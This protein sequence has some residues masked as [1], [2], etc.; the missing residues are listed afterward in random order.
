MSEDTVDRIGVIGG[1]G[2]YDIPGMEDVEEREMN[3]PFGAPSDYL[4]FGKLKGQEMVFLPRHGR[5]HTSS[6]TQVNYRANVYAMK[7]S[8]VRWLL[9]VS[10]VG[11]LREEIKPG[12]MV[13]PDQFIDRTRERPGTYFEDGIVAH[14]SLAD[15]TCHAFSD[16]LE[17]SMEGVGTEVHRGK[18]YL[19]MEGPQFSTRAESKLYRSW[20]ADI[21]GMTNFTEARLAREA[22][23]CYASLSLS[24]DYDC[25]HETEEDVAADKVL[26]TM[27]GNVEKAKQVIE[28][29]VDVLPGKLDCSCDT[30]LKGAIVTDFQYVPAQT[31]ER[32]GVIIA[33]YLNK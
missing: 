19:C 25:W 15:P 4:I 12:H 22:E 2:L 26:E 31:K 8:G 16:C 27:K 13:I 30:M 20:D 18:T 32:L 11:S 6:P 23:L 17:K 1:S 21:I 3:T 14:V 10:A 24:T 29:L 7:Q 28:K 5:H 33:K 9:S